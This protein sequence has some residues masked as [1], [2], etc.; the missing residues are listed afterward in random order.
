MA[1]AASAPSFV[2]LLSREVRALNRT[3]ESMYFPA[4]SVI[5]QEGDVGDGI[6]IIE[7]GTVEISSQPSG[8]ERKV[9][10][11]LYRRSFFGEMAVVD[12]RTRSATAIAETDTRAL[13]IRRDDV[14]A[15]LQNSAELLIVLMQEFSFRMRDFERR[16]LQDV[17]Q[18]ERL[19]LVGRFAQS[20]VHDFKNPLNMIGFAADV[21]CA[22]DATPKMR[23]ETKTL[24]RKQVDRLANMINE[25]LEF[26]RGSSGNV[27]LTR[28][29]YR[30]F[31]DEMLTD[32]RTEAAERNVRIDC[33]NQVAEVSVLMDETRL[34]HVFYNLIHNAI[35]VMPKGGTITM[36]FKVTQEDVVTEVEDSGPGI[37]P[38]I[39]P[40][41]FE[42]FATYGK[43]RGTGLGLSI[44]KRIIEDHKGRIGVLSPPGRGAIFSVTLPRVLN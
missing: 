11:H 35:D 10:A 40:R 12:N 32:L 31:V 37:A 3:H 27:T 2:D 33:E 19:A 1:S 29:N 18:A 23:S 41:L 4:G 21:G 22:D 9:F 25:L 34:L 24:I 28:S 8:E 5:F 13:F 36:R 7:E 39:A 26:S 44:C 15:A 30:D 6:Y 16:Y 17:I 42:P 43:S 20:I 14:L 38:E